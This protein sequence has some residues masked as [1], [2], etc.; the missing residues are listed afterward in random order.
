MCRCACA[1]GL[2]NYLICYYFIDL[3]YFSVSTLNI[4]CVAMCCCVQVSHEMLGK[5]LE[6]LDVAMDFHR[7]N[8][9]VNEGGCCL[10]SALLILYPHLHTQIGDDKD[11]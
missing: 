11:Q 6:L 10:L 9:D 7:E 8:V 5:W 3:I 2:C 4:K 1:F